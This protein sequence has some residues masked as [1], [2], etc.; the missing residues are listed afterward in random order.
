[1]SNTKNMSKKEFKRWYRTEIE[2]EDP[3]INKDD[4]ERFYGTTRPR[5]HYLNVQE[6]LV[7][8]DLT[9]EEL[10]EKTMDYIKDNLIGVASQ[11]RRNVN[12]FIS[13]SI[14]D[15]SF[16]EG[17]MASNN[18]RNQKYTANG[19][20]TV[21]NK[22]QN[23]RWDVRDDFTVSNLDY[24]LNELSEDDEYYE[25]FKEL[26]EHKERIENANI[27]VSGTKEKY[28]ELKNS[29]LIEKL[30]EYDV[31]ADLVV[32]YYEVREQLEQDLEHLISI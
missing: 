12:Y 8:A 1:M 19:I 10:R 26:E 31:E 9:R 22:S 14:Y 15:D 17:V 18:W 13:Y 29:D 24:I 32:K 20:I 2:N 6:K 23:D 30:W 21:L 16:N 11:L 4:I 25:Y 5:D 3:D 7:L 27:N 28:E